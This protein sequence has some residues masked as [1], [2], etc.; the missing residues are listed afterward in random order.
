VT[1][2]P[3]PPS[4]PIGAPPGPPI[5]WRDRIVLPSADPT[6]A[7]ALNVALTGEYGCGKT[8]GALSFPD[9]LLIHADRNAGRITASGVPYIN[10][11]GDDDYAAFVADVLPRLRGRDREF[12]KYKTIVY[13]SLSFNQ[14][15][16]REGV[17]FMDDET[18]TRGAYAQLRRDTLSPLNVLSTL[19][20]AP[21]Q[22]AYVWNVVVVCH[23]SLRMKEIRSTGQ[24]GRQIT[25]QIPLGYQPLL[26]GNSRELFN[27]YFNTILVLKKEK[28]TVG[29]GGNNP[30][31]QQT[32]YFAYSQ[33]PDNLYYTKDSVGYGGKWNPLPPKLDVTG[34][35]LYDEL[36]AAWGFPK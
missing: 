35:S 26:E 5:D 24:G 2:A 18:R 1:N 13:D 4:S 36:C 14:Q 33:E 31:Q 29:A 17:P 8:L 9:P 11:A 23:L 19:P 32:R 16:I 10:I 15:D 25:T 3:P 34:K 6:V 12:E 21:R 7:P 20:V 28:V 27:G 22:G 30:G